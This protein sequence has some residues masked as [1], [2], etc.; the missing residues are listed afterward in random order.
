MWKQLF[1]PPP[2]LEQNPKCSPGGLAGPWDMVGW[3]MEEWGGGG[4]GHG[5][6]G[7]GG[8]W[9]GAWNGAWIK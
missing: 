1:P 2:P 9:N 4:V 7:V 8:A 6:M 5:G 3:G